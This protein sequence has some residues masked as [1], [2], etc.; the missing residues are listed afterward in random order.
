MWLK[1]HKMVLWIAV[2]RFAKKYGVGELHHSCYELSF[3]NDK[4]Q[5]MAEAE[6]DTILCTDLKTWC[7]T[8][9]VFS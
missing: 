9:W 3:S 4:L 6:D 8:L 5:K 2:V 7:K 1:F